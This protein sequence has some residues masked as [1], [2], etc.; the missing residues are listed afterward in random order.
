VPLSQKLN[1]SQLRLLF[2]RLTKELRGKRAEVDVA[3]LGLGDQIQANTVSL[4]GLS[5]D[6]HDDAVAITLDGIDITIAK[7]RELHFDA[8]GGEWAT[9]DIVDAD[10]APHI[11]RL[12]EP[13][14]L[15]ALN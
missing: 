14:Q 5:Y 3:S 4:L 7:P 13:L 8:V 11:V 1:K 10:G 15:P 6:P 12:K 9:L 2:D